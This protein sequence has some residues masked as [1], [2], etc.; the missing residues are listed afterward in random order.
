MAQITEAEKI[1]IFSAGALIRDQLSTQP[2][3]SFAD[4]EST[5]N[6]IEAA[7]GAE[8]NF[9]V[10]CSKLLDGGDAVAFAGGVGSDYMGP[11]L[12][13]TLL[14]FGVDVSYV[15]VRKGLMTRVARIETTASHDR[16][17]AGFSM[18]DCADQYLYQSDLRT[19]VRQYYAG[20][21]KFFHSGSLLLLEEPARSAL[22]A[23]MAQADSHNVINSFDAN[24]RPI[25]WENRYAGCR[26]YVSAAFRCSQVGKL[27]DDELHFLTGSYDLSVAD[28]LCEKCGM[29]ILAITC[30]DQGAYVTGP[31][32]NLYQRA[33]YLPGPMVDATGAG[34]GFYA[35]FIVGLLPYVVNA[36]NPREALKKI[37][38]EQV[39]PILAQACAAGALVCGLPGGIPAMPTSAELDAFMSEVKWRS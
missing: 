1:R 27:A 17:L 28:R 11:L 33:A 14:S 13:N 6:V 16:H 34:D 7:G 4:A 5:G 37:T 26:D 31:W 25:L 32:G 35:A 2:G 3:V 12:K 8:A 24:I 30:A 21:L 39:R 18:E 10:A 23:A 22:W 29:Q 38:K 15:Y 20:G 19:A 9:A 36:D